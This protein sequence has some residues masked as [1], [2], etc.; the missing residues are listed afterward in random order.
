[1]RV[2]RMALYYTGEESGS[3]RI[4]FNRE[5]ADIKGTI[6]QVDSVIG[7]IVNKDYRLQAR[8]EKLCKNCDFRSFCDMTFCRA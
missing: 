3:P 8:P 1:V 5:T 4:T 6:D 2:D 7:K